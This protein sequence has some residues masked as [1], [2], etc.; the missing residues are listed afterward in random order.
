MRVLIAEDDPMLRRM[1]QFALTEWGYEVVVTTD[2]SEALSA[3]QQSDA[4]KLALLDWIMPGLDGPDVCRLLRERPTREPVYIIL[5]TGR[6]DPADVV[7][8]LGAGANDYVTKPF[9][10]DELRARAR[11]GEQVVGLQA[12]LAGRVRELEAALAQVKRLQKLLPMC[13]YCKKVRDDS[14]YWQ[15]LDEYFLEYSDVQFSHGICPTCL[16]REIR[17]LDR[18][19]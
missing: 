19:E 2:G 15:Q 12:E 4:P 9:N 16:E 14:D 17:H 8:G 10:P 3:L 7:A 11:V 18:D 5:L 6:D 1:L 13:C